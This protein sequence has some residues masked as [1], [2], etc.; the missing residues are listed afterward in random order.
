[1][2]KEN[3]SVRVPTNMRDEIED[4]QERE[5]IDKRSEALRQ[6]VRRGLDR[7]GP[8]PGERLAETGT[9]VAGVGAIVAAVAAPTYAIPFGATTFVFAILWAS[10]RAYQGRDLV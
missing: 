5:G 1:M 10:V 3:L 2:S 4:F 7:G 8:A 6:V 9:G